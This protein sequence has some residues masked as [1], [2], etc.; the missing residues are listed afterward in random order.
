MSSPRHGAESAHLSPRVRRVDPWPAPLLALLF[1]VLLPISAHSHTFSAVGVGNG[2]NARVVSS[3]LIDRN[4]FLWVGSREGLFRYDGYEPM[5][6][7]P[8]PGNPDAISD[9][10][11]RCLYEDREGTLWAGTYSGGLNRFDAPSGRFVRYRHDSADPGSISDDSVLAIAEGPENRLWVATEGGLSQLDRSTG[12]F[13][14]FGHDVADPSSLPGTQVRSLHRGRSGQLWVGTVGGGVARWNPQTRTFARFDLAELTGGAAELNDIFS[15]LEDAEGRLWVG[16]RVGLVMLNPATGEAL[17]L[18]LPGHSE[19]LPVIMAMVADG[20]GRLW[21]GTLVHGVLSMDMASFEW[22]MEAAN[23]DGFGDGFASHLRDQPQM[24]LALSQDMLLVGTWGGG[25]YRTTSHST[26]FD[27]LDKLRSAGLRDNN[28]TALLATSEPGR[29]WLGTLRS[30]PQRARIATGAVDPEAGFSEDLRNAMVL[31]FARGQDGQYW[32]A[33]SRGLFSFNEAGR[34]TS[35][36]AHEPGNP[37]SLGEEAVRSLLPEGENGLWIGTDGGGLYRYDGSSGGLTHYHH[38]ADQ[39][40]SISGNNITAL[41]GGSDGFLW[42]GTRS[43]GLNQCRIENW[44][45]RRFTGSAE[46]PSG[47][48][49][50]HFQVTSLFRDRDGQVWVGT[51][52]G[53]LNQVLLGPRGAVN[54]FRHW[55]SQDGLLDDS[56]MAIEQ[57]LDDS[58]WLTT[59]HGL[60]RLLP[61]TGQVINYVPQSGLPARLFNPGASAADSR[62]IYFGSLEGLLSFPKGSRFTQRQAGNVQIAAIERAP[63]GKPSQAL[64]WGAEELAIPYGEVLSIKLAVLDLSESTHDYAYRLDAQDPWIGMG[65]QRQLILHGLAPGQY[66]LQA[67]GRDVFGSWGES[68]TLRLEIVPP[69]WKTTWFRAF[70]AVLLL[71]GALGVHLI[72]QSALRRSSREIQRL[73]EKREQA[74]EERLGTE[75]ELAVLTPRQKEVLQLIAEGHST[76]EIAERLFV[77]IKTVEAHRANLMERLDIHDVPGLVRLAIRAR[78]VSQY[79]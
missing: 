77:S 43:N 35:H 31:D 47:L 29:P 12:R 61:G 53:G 13:E 58:L 70:L 74:L 7:L 73:S 26:N 36:I 18:P 46:D 32:A 4:G 30:G 3:L 23:H 79:E 27:L 6:F 64:Y 8:N 69:Y 60:S 52:S 54:G 38:E 17:E 62:F 21:L 33:T 14:H 20:G 50:S 16:T 9:S 65:Q 55:T 39:P 40:D 1:A 59:R 41:L 15:L 57:D 5:A 42:V 37:D 44:S 22:Q 11:I 72:R 24:S 68:D 49:L 67:R 66:F 76:K 45:C 19:Y 2:L 56:I 78:L 28:I 75:A 63:P 51:G 71:A 48:E 25:V 34:Q 10:D